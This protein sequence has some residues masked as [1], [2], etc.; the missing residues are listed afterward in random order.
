MIFAIG[1]RIR[2]IHTGYEGVVTATLGDEMLSVLLDD[3]DEIPAFED[4]LIRIEDYRVPLK[5]NPPVKAKVIQGKQEKKPKEPDR[6]KIEAQYA[7]LK[8]LGIQLAFE[9]QY[10]LDGSTSDYNMYLI[11]DTRYDALYSF[12]LHLG[13]LLKMKS[14]GKINAVS[15]IELG[16]I[17]FDY[18]NELPVIDLEC[19]QVT[20]EGT[21]KKQQK[22]LKIKAQQFF[23][24]IK[25]APLLNIPVH[26][27]VIFDS[28]E[29]KEKKEEDLK[30]YT[31]KNNRPST[32]HMQSLNRIDQHSVSAFAHFNPEIDLHIE[33]LTDRWKKMN[34][35]EILRQQLNAFDTY[36][37]K[38]INVGVPRVFVIHGLGK[39]RLRDE[40]ASRLILN[41]DV[42]TFKNEYHERYGYGATE[43][44]FK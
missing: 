36:T 43:V 28:F 17:P 44:V 27:Y 1:S 14:N 32:I 7:I 6:P 34:K 12:S 20:T 13:T 42:A 16:Q 15:Y 26:H 19:W 38:A 5:K 2:F 24:N 8:S 18:L 4:D 22:T 35:A 33:Q 3:G 9:A 39:G 40:I 30:T 21:G 11:N 31:Q 29:V 41:P 37:S 25:T 10:N 23:K